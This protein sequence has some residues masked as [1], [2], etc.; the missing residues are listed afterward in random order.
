MDMGAIHGTIYLTAV[1]R[2]LQL[3]PIDDAMSHERVDYPISESGCCMFCP[4]GTVCDSLPCVLYCTA[5]LCLQLLHAY[6]Y[7][8]YHGLCLMSPLS[9]TISLCASAPAASRLALAFNVS[10]PHD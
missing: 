5:E 4:D 7:A 9:S 3:Y 1:L 8:W 6:A 2:R 10:S